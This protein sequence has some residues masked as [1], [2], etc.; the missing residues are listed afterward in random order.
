VNE[1]CVFTSIPEE[2][3]TETTF[4]MRLWYFLKKFNM[5]ITLHFDI[6]SSKLLNCY[7][8]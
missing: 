7:T 1:G 8:M 2:P 5:Y 3:E 6:A 4:N